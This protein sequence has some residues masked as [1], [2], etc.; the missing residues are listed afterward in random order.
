MHEDLVPPCT[1]RD[2]E[3]TIHCVHGDTIA[4]PLATIKVSV[5]GENLSV[6]AAISKTLLASVLLGRDVS[7][8]MSVLGS[9]D[10]P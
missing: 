6:R 8:L 5:G 9:N 3:V 10:T 4:Y 1:L 7:E 2:G